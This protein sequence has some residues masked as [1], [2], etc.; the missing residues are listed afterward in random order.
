MALIRVCPPDVFGSLG[1][2]LPAFPNLKRI[3][4]THKLASAPQSLERGQHLLIALRERAAFVSGTI[5]IREGFA[6]D[7][8]S[9][10]KQ[11]EIGPKKK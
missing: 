4:A 2:P 1:A 5:R 10:K 7:W 6:R 8:Y 9:R 3:L 11:A